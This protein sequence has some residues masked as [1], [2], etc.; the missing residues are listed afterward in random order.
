MQITRRPLVLY[1]SPECIGYAEQACKYMTI[2]CIRFP[3]A[4]A[5]G[6]KFGH[7]IKMVKVNPVSSFEQIVLE[8]PMLYT[9]FQDHQSLGSKENS[10]EVFYHI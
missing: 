3:H 4:E 10:F 1:R 2:C 9:K 6:N 8:Y 5:L 7:V